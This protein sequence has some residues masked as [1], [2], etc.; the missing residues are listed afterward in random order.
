MIFSA[1]TRDFITV[2]VDHAVVDEFPD[3]QTEYRTGPKA[4]YFDQVG[5]FAVW[6]DLRNR[7][8]RELALKPPQL[9][10]FEDLDHFVEKFLTESAGPNYFGDSTAE[11]GYH[12]AGFDSEGKARLYHRFWG[13]PRPNPNQMP[14]DYYFSDH[15]PTPEK[16]LQLVYN[17][18][19]DI[20]D[21]VISLLIREIDAQRGVRF[22]LRNPIDVACLGDFVARMAAELTREVAP[23]FTTYL[24]LPDNGIMP[25]SNDDYSPIDR[26]VMEQL[27][28]LVQLPELRLGHVSPID[29]TRGAHPSLSPASGIEFYGS[30]PYSNRPLP[31]TGGTALTGFSKPD[32]LDTDE[33]S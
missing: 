22:D 1:A 18:R 16:P 12:I 14:A 20:A 17:G 30:R 8:T 28:T 4:R 3:R 7:I 29:A 27:H 15:S 13:Y 25:F 9:N 6:G 5:C 23:P 10:C 26:N 21:S 2:T 24:I 32:D 11:V 31:Y 19:N 33:L